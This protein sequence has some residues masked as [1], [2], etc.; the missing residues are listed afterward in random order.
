MLG[1]IICDGPPL[2]IAIRQRTYL[3]VKISRAGAGAL[4]DQFL[5]AKKRKTWPMSMRIAGPAGGGR[6]G[7]VLFLQLGEPGQLDDVGRVTKAKADECAR[8]LYSLKGVLEVEH[9]RPDMLLDAD[10]YT[11]EQ[12]FEVEGAPGTGDGVAPTNATSFNSMTAG[13]SADQRIDTGDTNET[14]AQRFARLALEGKLDEP[15]PEPSDVV[16]PEPVQAARAPA[17]SKSFLKA[18]KPKRKPSAQ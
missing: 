7:G 17:K 9:Y 4:L 14:A 3:V 12:L 13:L 5:T 18:L 10:D 8:W 16:Q 15:E 11:F 6:F 1:P 2:K